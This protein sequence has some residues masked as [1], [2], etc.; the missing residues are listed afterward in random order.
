MT[1]HFIGISV[2][3]QEGTASDLPIMLPAIDYSGHLDTIDQVAGSFPG[4]RPDQLPGR[5]GWAVPTLT[6]PSRIN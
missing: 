5:E 3:Q 6:T 2:A 4:A 1:R